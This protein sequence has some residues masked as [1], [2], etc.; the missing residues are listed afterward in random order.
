MS[1]E[2]GESMKPEIVIVGPMHEPTQARLEELFV[3]HRLW[4]AP[5]PKGFLATL[6]ERVR[7]VSLFTLHGCPASLIDAL[8]RLEIISSF[9]VGVDAIDVAC[10]RARGIRV[11]NTPEVLTDDTAD[12]ALALIL[13]VERQIVTGDRFVRSG[14]WARGELPLGRAL[15]SCRLGIV[16]MGRIGQAIARRARSFGMAIA[17]QGPREKPDLPY[18]YVADPVALARD[19]DILAIACPG[20]R[21]THHLVDRAVL[22]ALGPRGTLVNIARGSVVDEKALV[23]ALASGAIG[24]AGLDVYEDEPAVPA[25]L[26]GMENVVLVPHIGSATHEARQAMGEIVIDNLLAHFAGKPLLTPV[27]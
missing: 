14:A 22:E 12:V 24:G 5:D 1:R 23:E 18:R 9:G 8:P 17:Y 13:A 4:E 19:C 11:T 26:L 10:A 27:V 6:G 7:A 16:G 2:E 21:A 3:A 15:G 20:G 25:A